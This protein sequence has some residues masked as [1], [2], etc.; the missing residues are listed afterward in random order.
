VGRYRKIG[1]TVHLS[2]TTYNNTGLGFINGV[3]ATVE[4]G[5]RP[6]NTAIF[7]KLAVDNV[8]NTY[9]NCTV[10]VRTNGDIYVSFED[11]VT[12]PILAMEGMNYNVD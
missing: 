8:D 10:E 6:L 11:P 2:G 4:V 1:N 5:Y 3:I 7:Y 9:H 12:E